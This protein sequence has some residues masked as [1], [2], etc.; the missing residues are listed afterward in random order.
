[1]GDILSWLAGASL[2]C[3]GL[4]VMWAYRPMKWPRGGPGWLQ[5]AI[6]L[7]FFSAVANTMFWQVY[8]HIAVAND[9]WTVDRL[10]DVGDWLDILFKGGAAF[11]GWMHLKA[12]HTTLEPEERGKWGV[13]EIAFYPKRMLCLRTIYAVLGRKE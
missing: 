9:L 3:V 5:A 1:M 4:L 10:R 8:G 12:L 7:A 6:F 13:F 2:V 11:A